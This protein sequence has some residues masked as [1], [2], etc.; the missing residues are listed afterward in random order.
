MTLA[1]LARLFPAAARLGWLT[2]RVPNPQPAQARAWAFFLRGNGA[3][4]SRGFGRV[5]AR[6]RTA[7]IWA[8]DLCCLG[9][10]WACRRLFTERPARPVIFVGHSRGGRRA[11]AAAGRLGLA[12]IGVDL[13]ICVDVAYPPPVPANVRRAVHLYRGGR[14]L[15]PARPLT[16]VPGS[17]GVVENFDLDVEGAPLPGRW[18]HHFNITTSAAV[19]DWIVGEIL[20]TAAPV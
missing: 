6:L 11:L 14:R 9:D 3:F 16:A 2:V 19:Q 18:L 15:Y 1:A 7:G 13:L 10:R 5:C 20:K 12:E 17:Q 4:F 8:E